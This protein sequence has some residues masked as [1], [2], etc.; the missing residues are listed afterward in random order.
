VLVTVVWTPSRH[1]VPQKLDLP[2]R[3]RIARRATDARR[4]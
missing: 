3:L 4:E 2:D 1:S